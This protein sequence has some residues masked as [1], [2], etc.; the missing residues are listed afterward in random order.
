MSVEEAIQGASMR[1]TQIQP[2]GPAVSA[3]EQAIE[4]GAVQP[5]GP[6]ASAH[7]QAMEFGTIQPGG[8][9]VSVD[10][11]TLEFGA[12][13]GKGSVRSRRTRARPIRVD[14]PE[15][16]A[17]ADIGDEFP[18]PTIA[19]LC[20]EFA[21]ICESA[22]DALE[23]ASALEFAGISDRTARLRY[24]AG[25]DVFVLAQEMYFRVPRRP[26][27]PEPPPD[28]W[29]HVSK[30][31]P[32]LRGLLYALPAVCFPAAGALLAGPGART[33]LVVALLAGWGLSQGLASIGYLRLSAT[34]TGQARRVLRVGLAVGLALVAAAMT[35]TAVVVHPR[36][37]V[38]VFG[39]SE[40]AYMLA[41]CVLLVLG[42]QRWLLAALVPAVLASAAFL[43]LH[44]PAGLVHVA[45]AGLAVTVIA[46]L[47]LA[48]AFT[49]RIS[50]SAGRLLVAAELR[51]ALPAIGFGLVAAG[52]L[53]FPVL[54][55][56]GGHGG[57]NVGALLVAVPLSLSMG[58]AEWSLL[59]YR[60]RTQRLLRATLAP[61][62]FG[63]RARLALLG[64]LLEYVAGAVALTAAAIGIAAVTG[65]VHPR[66]ALMPEVGT[67]LAL[68]AAMFL[69]LL[70]Q[71]VRARGLPLAAAAT[72]LAVEV[73]FRDHGLPVQVAAATGLL[74]VIGG[75]A[76]VVLGRAVRNAY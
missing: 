22:V 25:V 7:E 73:A 70:L 18:P 58:T 57:V 48:I 74:V 16:L 1:P 60:R 71:A 76:A 30:F 42:A 27:E 46:A 31:Q 9:A 44:K 66:W 41:A 43:L 69:A 3:D 45:W 37:P 15:R 21:E 72:A 65:L 61:R 50:P 53:I 4:F 14:G 10:E 13:T 20:D 26:A 2:G 23:I 54:A 62:K 55:G 68:G 59:R 75:Y 17:T 49:R 8:R 51:A 35:A 39:A 11:Q 67:Y 40:G 28:P 29:R 64:A 34:D 6:A 33:V 24:G 32:A 38:L 19:A 36:I 56:P 52:L 47:V 12:I 63:R 5:G